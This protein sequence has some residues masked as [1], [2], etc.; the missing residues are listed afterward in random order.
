MLHGLANDANR[1]SHL[2]KANHETVVD[3]AIGADGNLEVKRLVI[4]VRG[5]FT[6]VKGDTACPEDR[7]GKA[8]AEG[9]FSGNDTD[10]LGPVMD[11]TVGFDQ[12]QCV[13]DTLFYAERSSL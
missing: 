4:V 6:Q 2:K 11:N 5:V 10:A 1:L 3:I 13:T 9:G 12:F 7:S 8:I